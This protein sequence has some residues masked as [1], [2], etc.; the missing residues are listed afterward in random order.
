MPVVVQARLELEPLAGKAKVLRRRARHREHPAIGLIDR[1]PDG[2][3][4][5]VR[6]QNR[7]VEMIDM[8]RMTFFGEAA[9]ST[10]P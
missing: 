8:H 2:G 4:R 9:A 6:H 7:T 1:L 3:F 10:L 5:R